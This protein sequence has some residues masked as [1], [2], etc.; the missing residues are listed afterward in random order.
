MAL[1]EDT[2]AETEEKAQEEAKT[3][4][5][6]ALGALRRGMASLEVDTRLLGMVSGLLIIWVIFNIWS[7]GTF[8]TPRNLW[9]LTVQ[10]SVVAIMATGMVLIIVSRN[11][12]L[13][14]QVSKR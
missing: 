3:P 10:T 13:A 8:L 4:S 5:S 1:T 11:I 7:G 2:T 12:D 9:N 6:G 14:S